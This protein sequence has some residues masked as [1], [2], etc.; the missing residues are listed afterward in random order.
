MPVRSQAAHMKFG[1]PLAGQPAQKAARRE[2]TG[3][4]IH[5]ARVRSGAQPPC[6]IPTRGGEGASEG[7]QLAAPA[8]FEPSF[9]WRVPETPRDRLGRQA[10]MPGGPE[11][12]ATGR[13]R[14][15]IVA[16]AFPEE[17]CLHLILKGC[18]RVLKGCQEPHK[19]IPG[20]RIDVIDISPS[21]TKYHHF[22][23]SN[24]QLDVER[25]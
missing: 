25:L 2:R 10:C 14:V 3:S 13:D 16:G 21:I 17:M 19:G 4:L 18:A 7:S 23:R 1:G 20:S 24:S 15:T 22:R 12:G 11:E 5:P 6:W 8:S 9:H